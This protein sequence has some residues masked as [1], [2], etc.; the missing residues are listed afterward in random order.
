MLQIVEAGVEHGDEHTLAVEAPVVNGRH[1]EHLHLIQAEPIVQ[2]VVG[3]GALP[4]DGWSGQ[5]AGAVG[6][7]QLL[8][9][10][11]PVEPR[12]ERQLVQR[13][14]LG[15]RRFDGDRVEPA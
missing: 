3:A 2:L 13:G 14:D 6:V 12:H 15:V 9:D 4:R 1:A 8:E 5:R 10:R 7:R 11:D